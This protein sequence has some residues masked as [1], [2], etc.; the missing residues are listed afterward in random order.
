MSR[1]KKIKLKEAF[2][3]KIFSEIRR[4]LCALTITV[5]ALFYSFLFLFIEISFEEKIAQATA[6]NLKHLI[7]LSQTEQEKIFKQAHLTLSNFAKEDEKIFSSPDRCQKAA[8][9]I[10]SL[11]SDFNTIGVVSKEGKVICDTLPFE[12]EIDVSDRSY[13]Q[14]AMETKKFSIGTYQI[15]KVTDKPSL[16][17]GYPVLDQNGNVKRVLVASLNL[18][19]L[20]PFIEKLQLPAGY[21]VL[22]FDRQGKILYNHPNEKEVGQ[23][24]LEAPLFN[25]VLSS[26]D[27]TAI[28]KNDQKEKMI[29]AFTPLNENQLPDIIIAIGIP[30]K[31]VLDKYNI[32]WEKIWLIHASIILLLVGALALSFFL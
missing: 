13:I 30:Q 10:L 24:G 7:A 28:F 3:P 15:G 19:W 1:I 18:K 20:S 4:F 6:L 21:R 9:K 17:F 29:Y 14:K 2:L 31:K 27:G 5:V 11:S 8:Q 26:P 12:G 22:V 25:A 16:N 23:F 32:G